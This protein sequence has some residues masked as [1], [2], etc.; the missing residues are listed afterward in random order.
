MN[1]PTVQT[2]ILVDFR[3]GYNGI[4][5]INLAAREFAHQ[6]DSA[7]ATE[8][9]VNPQTIKDEG[10]DP[11]A[12]KKS[13]GLKLVADKGVKERRIQVIGLEGV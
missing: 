2:G 7:V 13:T 4:G 1:A 6:R 8:V 11:A 10:I 12:V 5:N 3:K 9:H